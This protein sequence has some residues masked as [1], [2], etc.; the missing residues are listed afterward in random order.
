VLGFDVIVCL[1]LSRTVGDIAV[2]NWGEGVVGGWVITHPP[3]KFHIFLN[4]GLTFGVY[5][6]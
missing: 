4:S 2:G 1:C 6:V 3:S 5:V